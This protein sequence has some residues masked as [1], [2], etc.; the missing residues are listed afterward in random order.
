MSLKLFA[1][2]RTDAPVLPADDHG[3]GV[4]RRDHAH[5][6]ADGCVALGAQRLAR[7]L[8]HADRAAGSGARRS[9]RGCTGRR[10]ERLDAIGATD[11]DH[12]DVRLERYLGDAL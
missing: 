10:R 5:R 7:L 6:D 2:A 4:T 3:V 9:A 8:P 12:L 11:Q 1:A